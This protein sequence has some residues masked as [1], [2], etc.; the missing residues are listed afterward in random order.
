MRFSTAIFDLDG[1]LVDSSV[2]IV[3]AV[4]RTISEL[5]LDELGTEEIKRCI[6]PPIGD[7]LG[8]MYG[9]SKDTIDHFYK[10]FRPIY[11][12]EYLMDCQVYPGIE[13]LLSNLRKN[14]YRL[15]VAT[16][17]REDYASLLLE[18]IGISEYFDTIRAKDVDNKYT[19]KDL[20]RLCMED[21]LSSPSE[22]VMIGDTMDDLNAAAQ[23][24]VVFIGV[25]YGF[26]FRKGQVDESYADS[27]EDLQRL[28]I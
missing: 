16:N 28:L 5:G 1:T 25:T 22:T 9:Y 23:A 12:D 19:K 8:G 26:G 10:V 11:R 13:A 2:G 21:V 17:K 27:P 15:G 20:I 18:R 14:G 4:K 24:S 7:S 3:K 6:G